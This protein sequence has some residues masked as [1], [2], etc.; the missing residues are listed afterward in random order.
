M[1]QTE[2]SDLIVTF[3]GVFSRAPCH[4]SVSTAMP[5]SYS[6][7]VTP[8]PQVSSRPCR[9]RLLPF[10]KLDSRRHSETRPVSSSHFGFRS[11]RPNCRCARRYWDNNFDLLMRTVGQEDFPLGEDMQLGFH[12]MAQSHIT[13]GRNE[14][15]LAHFL[16]KRAEAC[17]LRHNDE[18]FIC[19]RAGRVEILPGLA[20]EQA[21]SHRQQCEKNAEKLTASPVSV[22]AA[23]DQLVP[24]NTK[25]LQYGNRT[26]LRDLHAFRG[27]VILSLPLPPARRPLQKL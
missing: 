23:E 13:F 1:N 26:C 17:A 3:F 11:T 9:S 18:P 7:S 6:V 25:E 12:S 21:G 22:C 27:P 4:S 8:S 24:P 5:P 2:P 16:R 15:A 10:A 19:E 20:S 14:P